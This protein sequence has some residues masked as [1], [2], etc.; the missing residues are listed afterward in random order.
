M[1][2]VK[3]MKDMKKNV[4]A[5][6]ADVRQRPEAHRPAGRFEPSRSASCASFPS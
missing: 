6:T 1:K 4:G 2:G 5:V 3:G